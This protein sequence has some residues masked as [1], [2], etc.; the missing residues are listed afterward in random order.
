MCLIS[1]ITLSSSI[2]YIPKAVTETAGRDGWFVVLVAGTLGTLN[3]LLFLWLERL[4]PGKNLMEINH[5]LLGRFFGSLLN[6]VFIFYFI[7]LCTWVIREFADFLLITVEPSTPFYVYVL[8]A[9][10]LTSYAAMQGWE[11]FARV[12]EIIFPII[13]GMYLL[14]FCFLFNQY[15]PQYLLPVLENG[16][17]QPLKGLLMTETLFSD[18]MIILMITNHV[19]KTAKTPIYLIVGML[20]STFFVSA[21]VVASIMSVG[22]KTTATLTYPTFS[23]IQN[24]NIANFLDRIDILII[25]M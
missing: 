10:I 5:I 11:V 6:F 3:A 24:I 14:I 1:L 17:F 22:A 20:L 16:I 21:A 7:D 12:S 13:L 2:L 23:L 4:F 25:T 8:I 19:R 15:N 18:V 9:L